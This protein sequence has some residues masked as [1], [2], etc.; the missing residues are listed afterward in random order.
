MITIERLGTPL[1]KTH[2]L[3]A[4]QLPPAAQKGQIVRRNWRGLDI[5]V[6]AAVVIDDS[7]YTNFAYQCMI[8]LQPKAIRLAV[9]ECGPQSNPQALSRLV[10]TL[11]ASLDGETNW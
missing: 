6:V 10:D 9:G 4:S 11:L 8:P 2:R 1:S 5:D 3:T 7:G